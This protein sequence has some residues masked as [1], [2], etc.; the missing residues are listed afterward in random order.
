[1]MYF[2]RLLQ[3][4]KAKKKQPG[5]VTDPRFRDMVRELLVVLPGVSPGLGLSI[6]GIDEN[7]IMTY[8]RAGKPIHTVGDL[9]RLTWYECK[10]QEDNYDI[11]FKLVEASK[12]LYSLNWRKWNCAT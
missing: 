6:E 2:R 3:K 10:V 5:I 8:P 11:D 4:I 1:M 12:V 9:L 7:V